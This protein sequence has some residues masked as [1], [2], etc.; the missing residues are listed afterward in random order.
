MSASFIQLDG[1]PG[2][3]GLP[4]HSYKLPSHEI[5][6]TSIFILF[7]VLYGALAIAWITLHASK[8]I[9]EGSLAHTGMVCITFGAMSLG[10]NVLNKSLVEALQAPSLI[11]GIQMLAT[12]GSMVAF[13]WRKLGEIQTKHA[14]WLVV[15]VLFSG[16]LLSSLFTFQYMNLSMY[17]IIRNL[18]P[19][20]CLPIEMAVMP[21]KQ[22]PTV[23]QGIIASLLITLVGAIIYGVD[24][25][26]L[27]LL[28]LICVTLNMTL[29]ISDRLIQRR[30][31]VEEC[32]DLPTEACAFLNNFVGLLPAIL[33]AGLM[34]EINAAHGAKAASWTDPKVMT[35]LMLS[36]AIGLGISY[37]GLAAQRACTATSVMVLQNCVKV[38][39]ILV[40][41][42]FFGDSISSWQAVTGICLSLGGSLWYSMIQM[43]LKANPPKESKPLTEEGK[44]SVV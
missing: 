35:L 9:N 40:G 22:R 4:G 15:P 29:G 34:G 38:G 6:I 31:M 13:N 26:S 5:D 24:T 7:A 44:K 28:G 42:T 19:L 2:H 10:M 12:V 3:A 20:V 37:F 18:A 1:V 30:L 14:I 23:N 27:T 17:T 41:V 8:L 43:E 33:A 25:A 11:T 39:V 36:C 16:M 32:K 21:P